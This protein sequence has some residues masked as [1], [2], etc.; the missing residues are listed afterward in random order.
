MP[1]D[2]GHNLTSGLLVLSAISNAPPSMVCVYIAKRKGISEALAKL[3]LWK[4]TQLI[5]MM[6]RL[7][8]SLSLVRMYYI[9][10]TTTATTRF[11]DA[12]IIL[13]VARV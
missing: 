2:F 11:K 3:H 12:G 13:S 5:G 1:P 10:Y 6:R 4:H 8:L 7:S 9:D